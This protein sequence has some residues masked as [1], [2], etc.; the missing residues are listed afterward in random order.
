M[1]NSTRWL[2][3]SSMLSLL[4]L[5]PVAAAQAQSTDSI[6]LGRA[7]EEFSRGRYSEAMVLYRSYL[8]LKPDDQDAWTRFAAT[9]Y[10]T[11]QAKQA[12]SYLRKSRPSGAFRQYNL[13]YQA[14]A[15]D[16]LGDRLRAKRLLA[17]VAK[18]DEALAEDALFEKAAIE[19]ED[20]DAAAARSAAEDYLKRFR[21]GR[22]RAPIEFILSRLHQAGKLEIPESQ[23][24]RYRSSYFS[25]HPLS[26]LSLPHLWHYQ[27]GYTYVRGTRSNPSY[28]GG[29]P[30]LE[31]GVA[32]EQYK[33][34]GNTGL[35]LGP[36]QGNGTQSY[37]G[38]VYSQDWLSDGDRMSVFF[39]DPLDI[40]YFPFRPDLMERSHRLFVESS[41]RSGPF[42][43]GAYGH[44]D[45]RRA[46]SLLFPAPERP[47]IRK[48][49]NV[50]TTT[51][52][53]PWVSWSYANQHALKGLLILDKQ[54]NREQ[55]DFSYKTYNFSTSG[56]DPFLSLSLQE[57]SQWPALNLSTLFEVFR[58]E[59][60][61]NDYWE[62]YTST[63]FGGM[64]T[65]T[66]SS[67][68]RLMLRGSYTRREYTAAIIKSGT[69][70][71]VTDD[72]PSATAITCDRLDT[73]LKMGA[74]LSYISNNQQAFTALVDYRNLKND[75]LKV[76]DESGLEIL[77]MFTQAF[78]KL[79]QA[80]RFIEPYRG[81]SATRGAF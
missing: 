49:F 38:Y 54:I 76:Y 41:G 70:G 10:H 21:D 29:Q 48:S 7:Q 19:F 55:P 53:V 2:L 20:G 27:I 52:L 74:S 75:T 43:F 15:S 80:A 77:L 50:S 81:L 18:A 31:S 25:H 24:A 56:E 6:L 45:N 44:W 8:R 60:L 4:V 67:H 47:E 71:F 40:Q 59:Q 11:G 23:R 32:F 35:T 12:L 68:W 63:G 39:E 42:E 37:V 28:T 58:W 57:L 65:W 73:F 72:F 5:I 14:L 9:Y 16:A 46:G 30:S 3:I 66:P 64:A 62:G 79:E 34:I 1:W 26:L 13:Y 78:P 51:S 33:L 22:Y 17:R 61:A 69:C 36:F